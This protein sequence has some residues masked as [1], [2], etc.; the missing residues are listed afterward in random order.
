MYNTVLG[1]KPLLADGSAFYYFRLQFSSPQGLPQRALAL[2]FRHFAASRR[3]L[4]PQRLF[5]RPKFASTSICSC[6]PR[7]AGR[8]DGAQLS[9]TQKSEYPFEGTVSFALTASTPVDFSLHL[10]IPSGH[11]TQ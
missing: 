4:S 10:R 2:L 7:C 3:R 6:L 9:V 5:P 11:K 1:A 8:R